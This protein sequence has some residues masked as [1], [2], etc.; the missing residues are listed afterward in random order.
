MVK[1]EVPF[2]NRWVDYAD[3]TNEESQIEPGWYSWLNHTLNKSPAED[4]SLETGQ[5]AWE[6]KWF[7]N[8]T[9][10]RGAYKPYSTV[11]E[12]WVD[13]VT[14]DLKHRLTSAG[15]TNGSHK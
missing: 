12:K 11:K 1:D 4:K 14:A 7:R 8:P 13:R 10:T 2:R 5:Y 9:M 3:F 15:S 6:I